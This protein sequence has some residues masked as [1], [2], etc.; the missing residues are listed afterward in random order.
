VI[1]LSPRLGDFNDDLRALG[2]GAL[3]AILH[4]QLAP[5]D[6]ARF[7]ETAGTERA[8]KRAG[9]SVFYRRPVVP[10]VRQV[11]APAFQVGAGVS[12]AGPSMA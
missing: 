4:P 6:V 3:R 7:L 11:R 8:G 1:G 5:P 2:R 9:G 12:R 10:P